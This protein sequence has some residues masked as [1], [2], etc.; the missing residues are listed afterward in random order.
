MTSQVMNAR[1]GIAPQSTVRRTRGGVSLSAIRGVGAVRALYGLVPFV[2]LM[3]GA[4]A[5]TGLAGAALLLV[6]VVTLLQGLGVAAIAPRLD[7]DDSSALA[8]VV[9]DAIAVVAGLALILL[10]WDQFSA[11]A[12]LVV[13]GAVVVAGLSMVAI[14]LATAVNASGVDRPRKVLN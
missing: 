6:G 12:A 2:F 13:L 4:D 5:G 3:T 8:A 1:I 10:A 9:A 11:S 14:A 7:R